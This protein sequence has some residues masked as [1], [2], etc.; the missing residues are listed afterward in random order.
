MNFMKPK[1][2]DSRKFSIW[3]FVLLPFSVLIGFYNFLKFKKKNLKKFNIPIICVGNIYLGGTGKTPLCIEIYKILKN[4]KRKP[5]FVKKF[6]KEIIDE[7]KIL[8]SVGHV[9]FEKNRSESLEL[10]EKENFDIAV[11]DDGFQDTSFQSN[12]S[13]LCFNQKQWIGNGFLIPSGPLRENLQSLKRCHCVV[14]NGEKDLEI[15]KKIL[16]YNS[17]VKIFYSN[18]NIVGIQNLDDKKIY[19]F[20]GIG[21]PSNFFDILKNKKLNLIKEK[22]FPDHYNFSD[23]EISKLKKEANELNAILVTTEKDYVRIKPEEK[24]NIACIKVDLNIHNKEEMLQE[25]KKIL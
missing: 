5:A 12:L 14:I 17:N 2:W 16:Q 13:I 3:P 10:L 23:T 24:K 18:Y 20:S 19:A 1:F 9:F 25:I 15:E 22:H 7:K 21:N 11:L 6:Y 4:L 8:E